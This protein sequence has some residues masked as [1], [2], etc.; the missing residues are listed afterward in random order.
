MLSTLPW[1]IEGRVLAC[2]PQRL[3]KTARRARLE[4]DR[5]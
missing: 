5:R 1:R 4:A 2:L 3:V